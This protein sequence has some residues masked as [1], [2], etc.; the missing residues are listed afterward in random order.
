MKKDVHLRSLKIR[1]M[2]HYTH[3]ATGHTVDPVPHKADETNPV[4][5][6]Y[7]VSFFEHGSD[8]FVVDGGQIGVSRQ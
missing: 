3:S 7:E 1:F 4:L 8:L 2:E 6:F 5:V